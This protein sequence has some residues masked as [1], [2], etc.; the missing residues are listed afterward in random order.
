MRI[1]PSTIPDVSH[2]GFPPPDVIAPVGDASHRNAVRLIRAVERGDRAHGCRER[3]DCYERC[4]PPLPPFRYDEYLV[5]RDR[6]NRD[7]REGLGRSNDRGCDP[8][9]H[10][11]L[12]GADHW[13]PKAQ[14][15]SDD[16]SGRLYGAPRL[17]DLRPLRMLERGA[18]IEAAYRREQT[19]PSGNVIDVFA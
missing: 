10:E 6:A 17:G 14:A 15:C 4:D 9:R 18:R 16:D 13:G 11:R 1:G 7:V 2:H 19:L 8:C 5:V 12:R 3:R